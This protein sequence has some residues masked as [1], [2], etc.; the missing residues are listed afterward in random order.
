MPEALTRTLEQFGGSRR[1]MLGLV[2]IGT[3]GLMW[4]VAQW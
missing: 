4:A 2:G 1:L 3:L